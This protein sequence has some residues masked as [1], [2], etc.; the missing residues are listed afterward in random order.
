MTKVGAWAARGAAAL[1]V[2]TAATWNVGADGQQGAKGSMSGAQLFQSKGCS[3]CHVGPDSTPMVPGFPPLVDAST[4][5]ADRR[6]GLSAEDYLAESMLVP[7]AFISPKFEG[8][9]GPADRMPQLNLTAAE[10]EAL[11]DYLMQR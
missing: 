2:A 1:A 4:W 5:A 9:N 3:G 11:V 7:Q 6:P 10:V 8:G